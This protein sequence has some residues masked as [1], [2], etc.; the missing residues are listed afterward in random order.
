MDDGIAELS[1]E[2]LIRIGGWHPGYAR[3]LLIEQAGDLAVAL[4][5]GNG[6]GAE[7][8]VEYWHRDAG[9]LWRGGSSS[10]SGPLRY[11]SGANSWNTGDFVAA[12]GRVQPSAEVSVQYGGHVHRRRASEFGVW[13]FVHAA[14]SSHPGD[15]PTVIAVAPPP[16]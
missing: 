11:L 15:L 8:E 4:V 7:L 14:D 5:D 9:G 2:A 1:A 6:D 10:G 12:L 3:V 16:V 13:G